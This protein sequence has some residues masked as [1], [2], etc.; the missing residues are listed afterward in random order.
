M[1]EYI[2]NNLLHKK[3]LI[4]PPPLPQRAQFSSLF[5]PFTYFY[6]EF[7]KIVYMNIFDEINIKVKEIRRLMRVPVIDGCKKW[8]RR[9]KMD[10]PLIFKSK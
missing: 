2:T 7:W 3:I 1:L 5:S 10:V 9:T 8:R 4:N 6:T